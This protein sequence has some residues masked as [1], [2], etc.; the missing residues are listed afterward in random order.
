[1]QEE[2]FKGVIRHPLLTFARK[3]SCT[4][5]QCMCVCAR[6]CFKLSAASFCKTHLTDNFCVWDVQQRFSVAS[7]R[8]FCEGGWA[9]RQVAALGSR[10]TAPTLEVQVQSKLS[11]KGG[12]R[13][14]RPPAHTLPPSR[15]ETQPRQRKGLL[16]PPSLSSALWCAFLFLT[17]FLNCIQTLSG[18]ER[19]LQYLNT[20]PGPQLAAFFSSSK[21]LTSSVKG[22]CTYRSNGPH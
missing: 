19:L 7:Q 14:T 2:G 11:V 15:L 9:I 22:G 20:S 18:P 10:R 12:V 5:K 8:C 13:L 16:L 4:R 1:M 21:K 3:R 6:A 17:F